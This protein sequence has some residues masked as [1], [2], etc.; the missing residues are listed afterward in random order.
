MINIKRLI[1]GCLET[2][3][4]ILKSNKTGIIIDPGVLPDK[5]IKVT[6]GVAINLMLAIHNH[7]LIG[8]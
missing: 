5:I 2:N 6:S 7:A 4:Y 3:C 8:I 1:V